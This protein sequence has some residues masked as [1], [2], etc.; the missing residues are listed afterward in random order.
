MIQPRFTI[1]FDNIMLSIE[2]HD[3]MAMLTCIDLL[4]FHQPKA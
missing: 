2:V 1:W 3:I 4:L